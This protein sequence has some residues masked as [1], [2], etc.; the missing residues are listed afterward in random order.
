MSELEDYIRRQM[1]ALVEEYDFTPFMDLDDEDVSRWSAAKE[2]GFGRYAAF[3]T[4]LEKLN[5]SKV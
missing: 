4:V 3:L 5:A 1:K 2:R